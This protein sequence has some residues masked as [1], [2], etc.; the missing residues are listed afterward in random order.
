[1][2][3][4]PPHRRTATAVHA[5][6]GE[7]NALYPVLSARL[8]DVDEIVKKAACWYIQAPSSMKSVVL[9]GW[10]LTTACG[11]LIDVVVTATRVI[12]QVLYTTTCDVTVS[13]RLA[14]T[15]TVCQ[16]RAMCQIHTVGLL[17]RRISSHDKHISHSISFLFYSLIRLHHYQW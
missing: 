11:N 7:G 3:V 12:S 2:C 13:V 4:C 1:M 17:L 10:L 6:G 14:D 5:V 9:A 15:V 16:C 8:V